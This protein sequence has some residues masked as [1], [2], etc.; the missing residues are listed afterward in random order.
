[1]VVPIHSLY[2]LGL[3]ESAASVA[4]SVSGGGGGDRQPGR[5]DVAPGSDLRGLTESDA[6]RE[7]ATKC[8]EALTP[9]PFWRVSTRPVASP[10]DKAGALSYGRCVVGQ[11]SVQSDSAGT[12]L[13]LNEYTMKPEDI[14]RFPPVHA[15]LKGERLATIRALSLDD[16]EGLARF[17][18]VIP[19]EDIRFYRPHPLDREHALTNAAKAHSPTEVVL[20]LEAAE[21]DIGCTVPVRIRRTR[22]GGYAWYRW[23]EETSERS[24]FGICIARSHQDVGAGRALMARLLEIAQQVGPPV[25]GLTVQLANERAL[26]LY[27]GMGFEVVREQMSDSSAYGFDP[28]PEYYMER[29]VR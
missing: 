19:R 13:N 22:I 7:A 24:G 4:F 9:T 10:G 2:R 3:Y 29:L 12:F 25:M 5:A 6:R 11:D 16:G 27:R 18:A 17:Y 23:K 8:R 1:M 21:G 28:E 26:R 14:Q 20:V 15:E